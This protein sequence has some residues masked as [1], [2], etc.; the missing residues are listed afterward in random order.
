MWTP[1]FTIRTVLISVQELLSSPNLDQPFDMDV[2]EDWRR[3]ED[4]AISTGKLTNEL[5]IK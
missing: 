2:G 5:L 3:N 4:A 1:A